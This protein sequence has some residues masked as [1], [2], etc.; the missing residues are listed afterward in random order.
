MIRIMNEKYGVHKLMMFAERPVPLPQVPEEVC[1]LSLSPLSS[2]VI[3]IF[4]YPSSL[5]LVCRPL[6]SFLSFS[7]LSSTLSRLLS[8]LP[9][10]PFSPLSPLPFPPALPSLLPPP[11]S[12]LFPSSPS[13]IV[14]WQNGGKL[15]TSA[16]TEWPIPPHHCGD[17]SMESTKRRDGGM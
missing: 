7:T 1:L 11:F 5:F 12:P 13:S 15:Q 10:P 2:F 8:P 17:V 6:A 3:S 9:S 4:S 16:K 14:V